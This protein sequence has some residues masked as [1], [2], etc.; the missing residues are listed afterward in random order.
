MKVV[1]NAGPLMV[2][3]K[4]GLLELLGQLYG[5]VRIPSAVYEEV[6]VQGEQRGFIDA[7][8]SKLMVQRGELS[9]VEVLDS[10]LAPAV[11][12]LPLDSGEKQAI[13][14]ALHDAAGLVLMDDMMARQAAVE[15]GI[16][17]KGT[18]GVL[19]EANRN[20]LV[21]AKQ[22]RAALEMIVERDDIW[23]SVELCRQVLKRVEEQRSKPGKGS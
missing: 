10:D 2:L 20:G 9:L 12:T 1:S 3:G 23:I 17:V 19:V 4:L 8:A 18:L 5:E 21:S 16:G 14:L 22:F 15:L 13:H 11:S 7:L 6:V